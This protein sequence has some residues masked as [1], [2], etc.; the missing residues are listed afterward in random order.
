VRWLNHWLK[1]SV[2]KAKQRAVREDKK[3]QINVIY[4]FS[5]RKYKMNILS[6]LIE[7][8]AIIGLL[9][10]NLHTG[11]ST[12]AGKGQI[13][14]EWSRNIEGDFSFAEKWSYPEGVYR[15]TY[16]QLGCDGFCP[17]EIDLMMDSTGLI[18][19]DSLKAFYKLIDTT[20]LSHTIQ[21]E[22]WCYEWAGTDFITARKKRQGY[23]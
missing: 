10:C 19:S 3:Y 18:Y 14:I 17:P 12:H 1:H 5:T 9:T 6:A 15:N 11:D 7:L 2:V 21:C 4:K 8:I 23:C 16:G 22:A 20:H 13:N